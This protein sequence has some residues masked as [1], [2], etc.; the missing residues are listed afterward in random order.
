V[1]A[2]EGSWFQKRQL[3]RSKDM[4]R[5]TGAAPSTRYTDLLK[6]QQVGK[7]FF[8]RLESLLYRVSQNYLPREKR[9]DLNKCD[10]LNFKEKK[11]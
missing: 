4:A 9:E 7:V 10:N 8:Q 3:S 1:L 6:L 5:E 11:G 2:K